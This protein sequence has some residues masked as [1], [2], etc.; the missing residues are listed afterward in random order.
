MQSWTGRFNCHVGRV[1]HGVRQPVLTTDTCNIRN[2]YD[3]KT[4]CT[5]H[6]AI[7]AT[8]GLQGFQH[9]LTQPAAIANFMMLQSQLTEFPQFISIGQ[10]ARVLKKVSILP[11]V[12]NRNTGNINSRI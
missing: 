12:F 9:S 4:T 1:R 2:Q 5:L 7:I 3:S 6:V 8:P 11:F 10:Y